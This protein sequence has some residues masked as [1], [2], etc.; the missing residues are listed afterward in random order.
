LLELCQIVKACSK[1][2]LPLLTLSSHS[3]CF[4]ATRALAYCIAD[5]YADHFEAAGGEHFAHAKFSAG[6]QPALIKAG[7]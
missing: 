5:A 2:F 3:C 4:F 7:I 1:T 6:F